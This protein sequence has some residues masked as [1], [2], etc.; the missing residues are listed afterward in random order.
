MKRTRHF[1][2]MAVTAM[3]AVLPCVAQDS[4]QTSATP[5]VTGSGKAGHIAVWTSGTNIGSSGII[6]TGGNIGIG[7]GTPAAKLEVNGDAQVDGNLTLGGNIMLPG[8]SG[9]VIQVTGLNSENVG[10]GYG[11]LNSV[12]PGPELVGSLNT[13]VGASALLQTTTGSDNT[14]VGVDALAGNTTGINNG[15]MTLWRATP[16]IS[17][18]PRVDSAGCQNTGG[19]SR[20]LSEPKTRNE[21]HRIA[22]R[23]HGDH[24]VR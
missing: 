18:P 24:L 12:T 8:V 14:A 10:V 15:S 7:T 17:L 22:S 2:F 5:A 6:A 4:A 1:V 11:A 20:L 13:A 3:I 19:P 16:T 21:L 9:P 23:S